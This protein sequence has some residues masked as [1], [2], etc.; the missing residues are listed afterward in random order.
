MVKRL[1]K[2]WLSNGTLFL[3]AKAS[4]SINSLD[5]SSRSQIEVLIYNFVD[6]LGGELLAV[7]S[8]GEHADGQWLGDADCIRNLRAVR[9]RLDG[10]R[11]GNLN[12]LN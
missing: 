8:I 5:Y 1:I 7:T 6:L 9:R 3:A 4:L 2:Q 11:N 10:A 12:Q